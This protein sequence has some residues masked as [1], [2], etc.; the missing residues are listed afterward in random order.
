MFKPCQKVP[1][2]VHCPAANGLF[3]HPLNSRQFINCGN[4]KAN[5]MDCPVGTK[6]HRSKH[7]CDY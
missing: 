4:W 3:P 5:V 7:L 1:E 6:Y 2:G